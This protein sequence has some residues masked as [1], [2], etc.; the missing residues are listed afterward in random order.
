MTGLAFAGSSAH[1]PHIHSRD[2]SA[3]TDSCRLIVALLRPPRTARRLLAAAFDFR[4]R[5]CTGTFVGGSDVDAQMA[6]RTRRLRHDKCR[7]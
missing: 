5:V 7:P 3:M 1:G 2:W 6:G 4:W